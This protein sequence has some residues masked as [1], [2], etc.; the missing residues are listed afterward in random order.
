MDY[1][2][3]D[4]DKCDTLKDDEWRDLISQYLA[5][6]FDFTDSEINQHINRYFPDLV[7]LHG[8]AKQ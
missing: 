7:G 5:D 8:K 2:S 4:L 6:V 1:T 3:F